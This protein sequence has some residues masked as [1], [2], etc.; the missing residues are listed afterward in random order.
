MLFQIH[1][2]SCFSL[3]GLE[4]WKEVKCK[5]KNVSKLKPHNG[6]R[7]DQEQKTGTGDLLLPIKFWGGR[8]E[9]WI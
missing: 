1:F 6:D 7:T 8:R 4:K 9:G 3:S 2:G 5:R